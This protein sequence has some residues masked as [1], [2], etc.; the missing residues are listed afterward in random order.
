MAVPGRYDTVEKYLEEVFDFLKTYQWV[1]SSPNTDLSNDELNEL[2]V[3]VVSVHA[4]P[5]LQSFFQKINK[6]RFT[7]PKKISCEDFKFPNNS[8]LSNKKQHE[9]Q[10]LAPL[11]HETCGRSDCD[12]IVDV[13]TGLVRGYL[14]R[15]LY[16]K[17]KYRVLG[18]E[19]CPQKFNLAK[20][21]QKKYSDSDAAINY[22]EHF[23]TNESEHHIR[24]ITKAFPMKHACITGLHACADLSVIILEL[25]TKL[26]FCKSLVIMPCCYHRL[27][28]TEDGFE[29]FPVSNLL[30][31]LTTKSGVLRFLKTPFLRLACQGFVGGFG[32]M[33]PEEHLARTNSC[34][35]RAVLEDVAQSE[36]YQVRRLKRK[37][38]KLKQADGHTEPFETYLATLKHTHA[39]IGGEITDHQFLD[40]MRE[41]WTQHK[42]DA[43]LVEALA[44]FQAAM[45]SICENVVLLDRVMFLKERG[46][47][48][49]VVKVTDQG[50]SP[51][52]HALVAVKP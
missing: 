26:E 20:T 5:S 29:N 44:A 42:R 46:I 7:L 13:G 9:I 16:D 1:F 8:G 30:K 17:Y 49:F 18:I 3:G 37:S 36:N 51:R 12:F 21:K 22:V 38:G 23:V 43:H 28:Q 47:E 6:L 40:K 2:S 10:S 19:G 27:K 4:P 31:E 39:L 11:I 33:T 32:N 25:F 34:L 45:Q 41:K 14:P 35:F 50:I 15:L 48:C 24:Q 52:C